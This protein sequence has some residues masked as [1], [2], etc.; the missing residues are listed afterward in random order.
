MQLT[1]LDLLLW[2]ASFVGHVALL[3]VL[4]IRRRVRIF[5][6]FTTFIVASIVRTIALFCIRRYGTK[7]EYFYSYWSLATVDVALQLGIVYEMMRQIFRPLGSWAKDVKSSVIQWASGSAAVAAFLTGFAKPATASWMQTAMIKGNFFT[8]TLMSELF[9]GMIVLS[10]RAGLPWKTHVARICQGWGIYSASQVLV[11]TGHTYFGLKQNDQ[12][13]I[14]LSHIRIVI[15]LACLGYWIVMLWREA[16]QARNMSN[17]MR[18][19]VEQLHES[20]DVDLSSLGPRG[21]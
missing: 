1:G 15:Y 7:A 2:L 21:K 8:S 9:V 6:I 14:E 13:Y 20:A 5:P 17:D 16:P 19:Q 12:V 3:L 10:V 4:L 18:R 11:E